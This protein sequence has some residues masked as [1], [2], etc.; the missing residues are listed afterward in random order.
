VGRLAFAAVL[1]G[2]SALIPGNATAAQSLALTL[3]GA[4]VIAAGVLAFLLVLHVR[5]TAE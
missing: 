1:V 5:R 2:L 4:G 3:D